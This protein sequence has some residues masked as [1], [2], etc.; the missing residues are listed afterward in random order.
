MLNTLLS[1]TIYGPLPIAPFGL[2]PRRRGLLSWRDAQRL[3]PSPSNRLAPVFL[4][5]VP[6]AVINEMP[7]WTLYH[8]TFFLPCRAPNTDGFGL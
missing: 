4:T 5:P 3:I 1:L 2:P 7:T 8:F 6:T